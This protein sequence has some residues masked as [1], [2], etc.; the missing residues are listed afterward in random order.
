[1]P[2]CNFETLYFYDFYI[3]FP[4]K[5]NDDMSMEFPLASAKKIIISVDS[6]H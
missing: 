3:D 6:S 5:F 4:S 1:M 2:T